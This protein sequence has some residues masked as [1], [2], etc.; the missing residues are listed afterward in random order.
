MI[1][2]AVTGM[3]YKSPIDIIRTQTITAED[4]LVYKA[5][6][7]V[8]VK[9]DKDELIKALAYDRGQYLKGYQDRDDQIVRCRNCWKRDYD[10]CPFSEYLGFTP[11]D[12]WY[13]ADGEVRKDTG[14]Q[15][16]SKD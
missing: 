7:N 5:V 11:D 10:N 1:D 16:S 13:C 15:A 9:V 6:L 2:K 4:D 12:D 8:D 14:C 3:D